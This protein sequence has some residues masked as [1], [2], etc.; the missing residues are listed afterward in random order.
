MDDLKIDTG[1]NRAIEIANELYS[2]LEQLANTM[3]SEGTHSVYTADELLLIYVNSISNSL[4]ERVNTDVTQRK[5]F[6]AMT[7]GG[8]NGQSSI[9]QAT[10]NTP[11]KS[12]RKGN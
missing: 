10:N 1:L 2:E 11:D 9:H 4:L 5:L 7:S 8:K 3:T 6:Q 12:E